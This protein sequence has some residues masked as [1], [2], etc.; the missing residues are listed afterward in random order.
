MHGRGT[1]GV[2]DS[3]LAVITGSDA[4]DPVTR[5]VL[6]WLAGKRSE[7]TRRAYARDIGITPQARAGRAPSWLAWCRAAG[8]G[9]L[10]ATEDHV[11]L[12]ARALDAAGLSPATKARKLSAVASWYA[13]LKRRGHIGASPAAEVKRPDVDRDTSATPGLTRDHTLAMLA[14]ADSAR[15]PQ[16]PRTAA[17]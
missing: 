15:G 1:L 13:W 10:E 9:P 12:Y 7:N 2:M 3:A 5:L 11:T 6:G 4:I 17:L 8:T 16:Q 14:A